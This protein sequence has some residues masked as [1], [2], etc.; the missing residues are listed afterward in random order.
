MENQETQKN[1]GSKNKIIVVIAG[2]IVVVIAVILF[3]VG[4]SLGKLGGKKLYT[5]KKD[6]IITVG[7]YGYALEDMMYYIY[8]EE[9]TGALYDEI[10]QSIYGA[11]YWDME[12][13]EKNNMTGQEISKK[14]VLDAI[15]KDLVWYQ[16]ALKAGYTLKEED[17]SAAKDAYDTFLENLSTEQKEKTGMGE[18]LLSYFEKQQVIQHYKDDLLEEANF[19]YD[20]IAAGVSKEE[21]RE[22][23]YEYFCIYKEDDEGKPYSRNELDKQLSLLKEVGSKVTADND[24]QSL[25]TTEEMTTYIEYADDSLVE[26]DGEGYGTY[27]KVDIDALIKGME[28]GQVSEVVD[29]DYAYY[30]FR[31]DDNNSTEAYETRIEELVSKEQNK[32]YNA[33]YKNAKNNYDIT[34][35]EDRWSDVT[36][37]SIIYG[38]NGTESRDETEE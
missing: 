29:A 17:K 24:M 15:K 4:R 12:D 18:A 20:S 21:Y 32:I 6:A 31:M 23:K 35:D 2:I 9:E 30:I 10:Y 26:H 33:S 34:V 3:F 28:N 1:A 22:Y 16:E 13:E 27:K 11:S 25:L 38:L 37:G 5:I 7:D 19:D 36:L 14:N 8:M